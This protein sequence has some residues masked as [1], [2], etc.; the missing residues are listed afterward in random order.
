MGSLF[1]GLSIWVDI[2]A[3]V[4]IFGVVIFGVVIFGVV[5]G[6]VTEALGGTG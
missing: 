5:G 2:C 3:V 4:V 1:R 6:V